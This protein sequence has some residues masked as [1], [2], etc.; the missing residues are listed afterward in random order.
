M[1]KNFFF[2]FCLV[3]VVVAVAAVWLLSE[4]MPEMFGAFNGQWAIVI[5]AGGI[6]AFF[7]LHAIFRKNLG[8]IKKF[9]LYV[10]VGFLIAA[11]LVLVNIVA[12]PENLVLPII[13]VAA[14]VALLLGVLIT[15]GK[16]WDTADNQKVGYK[17]YHQRKAEE[18]RE[19]K[20]EEKR[21]K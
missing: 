13:G 7:V 20:K 2:K 5:G 15:G 9:Y 16:K 8:A 12:F 10:G 6:G 19:A 3:L 18:E 4:L 21:N 17:N 11:F 1:S 14:A